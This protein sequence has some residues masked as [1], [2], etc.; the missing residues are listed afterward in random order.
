MFHQHVKGM[1]ASSNSA[2]FSRL[3]TVKA[4]EILFL[5]FTYLIFI[6]YNNFINLIDFDRCDGKYG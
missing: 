4:M 2:L 5:I 1:G 6:A 3:K